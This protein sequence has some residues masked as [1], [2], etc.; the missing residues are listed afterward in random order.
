MKKT[1]FLL[2]LYAGSLYQSQTNRFTYELQYRKDASAEYM[3]NLMNLDISPKSVKFYDKKFADYDAKNKEANQ[4]VSHYSTRTDQ[5]VE[6]K[7]DSF[8]NNWYRDF[9]DYFV[10]KTNDEMTWQLHQEMKE[11][12]GYKL[13][14]ATTDFGG[15][16]WNAWFS[17]DINIKE[18]PYKFRGLPGLIFI[19]EDSD[20]NF[21]Y[22]V[23]HNEKLAADYDTKEFLETH[24]GKPAIPISNEKFNKYVEDIYQNPTRMFS[25]KVKNGGNVSFKNE[26]IESAEELNKKKEMLQNGIKGRYIYIEKDK[27]PVF[28]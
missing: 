24:Y 2:A 14:K 18:G 10:V 9:F 11:Y 27:E 1:F 28:N 4:S 5:I 15:R 8:K 3:T 12:N 23:I 13:Q 25:E 6:R 20:Q 26:S 17:N 21:I 7:P 19:L 16:S 22:K